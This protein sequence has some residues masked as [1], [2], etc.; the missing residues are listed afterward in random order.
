MNYKWQ[1]KMTYTKLVWLSICI[2]TQFMYMN[3]L[4][5]ISIK[6]FYRLWILI[7]IHKSLFSDD[8]ERFKLYI[9]MQHDDTVVFF[10]FP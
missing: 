5:F 8:N 3:K 10:L 4:S 7:K 1:A 2:G 9:Y 6:K